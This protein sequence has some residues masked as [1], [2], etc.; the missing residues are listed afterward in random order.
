M[1]E[2][3]KVLITG[4]TGQVAAAVARAHADSCDLWGLARYTRAGSKEE[5]EAI[6]V[7]PAVG[8]YA[9]GDFSQVPDDFD[10]VLHFAA[11]TYPGTADIGM[12]QNAEGTGLLMHHCR[13][14]K[15][16][17]FVSSTGTYL[18]NPDANHV[19]KET[20]HLGGQTLYSPNYGATKIAAEG[21]VRA[22][23]RAFDL[24]A[25]VARLDCSYG[26]PYDDGGLP[27]T[28]LDKLVAGDT[29]HLPTRPCMHSPVHEDDL[30]A[31]I[32]PLLK[33][34]SVPATIVNW[35][36]A[37]AVN[38]EDWIHYL[39]GLTGL[40]PKIQHSDDLPIPSCITDTTFGRSIGLEWKVNWKDGMRR[41]VAARHP[42]LEIR[43]AAA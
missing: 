19:Y 6:G 16:F 1:L 41:M 13:K 8:D 21:V 3:K 11:N 9:I 15:A 42:E 38:V 26:G 7:T 33:A 23:A 24:P 37:D 29:I 10:Y 43:A 36:G 4:L 12:Q 22:M 28:H 25:T 27:G 5:A 20:D 31:H 34:A 14:A 35:G 17:L 30:S 32:G 40:T 2:G 18:D 39:A